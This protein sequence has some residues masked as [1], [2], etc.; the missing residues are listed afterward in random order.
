MVIVSCPNVKAEFCQVGLGQALLEESNQGGL[1]CSADDEQLGGCRLHP[2]PAGDCHG[3]GCQIELFDA[4]LLDYISRA[5]HVLAQYISWIIIYEEYL[6]SRVESLPGSSDYKRRLSAFGNRD[7][8]IT[9]LDSGL[10]QLVPP[11]IG[12][13]LES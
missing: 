12:E 5:L 11:E 2:S 3:A 1:Q 13:I 4:R 9:G 8:D 7:D 10:L 6:C